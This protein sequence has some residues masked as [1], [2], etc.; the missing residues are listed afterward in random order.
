MVKNEFGKLKSC[1]VGTEFNFT[2]RNID[3][4]FK[5]MYKTNLGI[6][7]LYDSNFCCY[8]IDQQV[9]KERR[10][11]LENLEKI[12]KEYGVNVIRPTEHKVPKIFTYNN[13]K[14][15][16]HSAANNVRDIVFTYA[17]LIIETRNSVINRIN[18][19]QLY[20]DQI[21]DIFPNN[22]YINL[23]NENF[24]KLDIELFH[25]HNGCIVK[26]GLDLEEWSTTKD[27]LCDNTI[28]INNY[29]SYIDAANMIK[30]N[31]DIICNIGSINQY[32]GFLQLQ[33]LF[34]EYYPKVTLHKMF[35]ADSHIDGTL[36]PLKEG[37]FLANE[38]FLHSNK[39]K[40]ELPEKFKNWTIIYAQDKHINEKIYWDMTNSS[41]MALASSRGMDINVLSIDRNKILIQDDAYRTIE[42]LDK[43]NFTPIPIRFR[44][45]E[46]FA[47][48]IHCSTLDLDRED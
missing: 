4:T 33:K 1:V 29:T 3:F 46:I 13:E 11:D 39:I 41:P 43:N 25:K 12:L 7:K 5:N 26:E 9:L 32:L 47:G 14:D 8:E 30:I 22:K 36:I 6:E 17:D 42:L 31:D 23:V 27:R 35:I 20:L 19:N 38:I 48:G 10:E 21:K 34:K 18:E 44:H 16:M 37:V 45:G 40:E 24:S 28:D 15:F 2:K